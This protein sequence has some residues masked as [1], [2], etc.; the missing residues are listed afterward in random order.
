[1]VTFLIA[2]AAVLGV[3]ALWMGVEALRKSAGRPQIKLRPV[4]LKNLS[5][6]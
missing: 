1:M 4:P 5:K 2:G 6:K 3:V